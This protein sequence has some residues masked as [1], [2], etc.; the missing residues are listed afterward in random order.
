[1]LKTL[2][3]DCPTY[4]ARVAG[5]RCAELPYVFAAKLG[6]AFIADSERHVR[7]AMLA[8]KQKLA[9]L[10]QPELFLILDGTKACYRQKMAMQA[11]PAHPACI[12]Q[13][14]DAKSGVVVVPDPGNGSPD[15]TYCAIGLGNLTQQSSLW[16]LKKTIEQ[17][18]FDQGAE[19]RD[20]LARRRCP[21]A[22]SV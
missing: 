9:S 20:I 18:P 17:F 3:S 12:A 11:C 22:G 14:L 4:F 2:A 13:R 19:N 8:S 16:A 5:W 1:M 6:C 7:R 21:H 15:A 10:L